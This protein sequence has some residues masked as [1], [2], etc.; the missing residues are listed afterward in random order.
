MSSQ[1]N[2]NEKV[3]VMLEAKDLRVFG[4]TISGNLDKTEGTTFIL[5]GD[6]CRFEL[7]FLKKLIVGLGFEVTKEEDFC[8]GGD[9][10]R[11]DL[12]VQTTFPWAQFQLL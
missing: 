12:L 8:W 10:D 3:C 7:L 4:G 1:E 5:H 2:K 9:D 6:T 11:C